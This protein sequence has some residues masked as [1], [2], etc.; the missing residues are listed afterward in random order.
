MEEVV[1]C[2]LSSCKKEFIRKKKARTGNNNRNGVRGSNCITCSGVCSRKYH[3][4]N[5]EKQ[6]I[7]NKKYR[8][9]QKKIK[10]EDTNK[11]NNKTGSS[12][13]KAS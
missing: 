8:E 12:V 11:A 6:K 7:Y 9:R 13:G 4:P 10:N 2:K 1:N 5:R 3:Y